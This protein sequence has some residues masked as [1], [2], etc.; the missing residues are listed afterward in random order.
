MI[1]EISLISRC[2]KTC[3][4]IVS[5]LF[6]PKSKCGLIELFVEVSVLC[7]NGEIK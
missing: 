5:K 7:A 6:N 1:A 4:F 2:R 3:F